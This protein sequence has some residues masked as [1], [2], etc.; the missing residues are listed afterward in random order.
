MTASGGAGGHPSLR[1]RL[2]V[3]TAVLVVLSVGI[4]LGIGLVLTRRSVE[5]AQLADLA[6]QADLLAEREREAL[7]PFVRL[8]RLKRFLDEQDERILV[9]PL[10]KP[11]PYLSTDEQADLRRGG[12]IKGRVTVDGTTYLFAA[13]LVGRKG[14]VLLRPASLRSSDWWPFLQGLL[15]AGLAGASLAAVASFLSA[16][17]I[18]RP[19]R[20]VAEASRALAGGAS[21]AP[22]PVEGS[23]EL[24]ALAAAFNDMA[25][26]LTDAREAERAFLLSVSHELKT[27]LTAIRGYA[28]GLEEELI[29]PEEAAEIIGREASRLERL[30]RDL[31][32]LAR[33]SRS[34]FTVRRE[35][36]DLSA[37]V[38]DACRRYEAEARGRSVALDTDGPPAAPAEGDPDRLL[39][40]LSNLVENAIRSTPPG[41]SVRIRYAPGLVA[42]EDT[43]KGLPPEELPRA[44]ERFF[45]YDRHSASGALGT[46][47][48]L[49]IVKELTE[50]MGGSVGVESDVGRGTRFSV[51]LPVPREAPAP[52][53]VPAGR[54]I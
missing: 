54:P 33:M 11:T 51:R 37:L 40:V 48:G 16:R 26:Q 46:G 44:F 27:P 8:G 9:V 13:R 41:G 50:A 23:A 39:Q 4:T 42:V 28:E 24:A 32:D 38:R 3:V 36:L 10:V 2:F 47:L 20:R 21:P 49:A 18:T 5:R 19:I 29:A 30:V 22:V 31:L 12:R 53:P 17:A 43:G 15:I 14:F 1:R 6:H 52:E 35:R 34:N 7:L 25:A 45:L